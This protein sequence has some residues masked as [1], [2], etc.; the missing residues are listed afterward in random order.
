MTKMKHLTGKTLLTK[1]KTHFISDFLGF[2]TDVFL[3]GNDI[4]RAILTHHDRKQGIWGPSKHRKYW[5]HLFLLFSIQTYSL[6]SGSDGFQYQLHSDDS[7]VYIS[8]QTSPWISNTY[9]QL[10][11]D[12]STRM[13]NRHLEQKVSDKNFQHTTLFF[14]WSP[15]LLTA[16]CLLSLFL[17]PFPIH[18]SLSHFFKNIFQTAQPLYP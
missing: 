12:I 5:E 17:I 10:T 6:V 8:I 3:H 2:S 4:L 11:F 14:L 18:R 16:L 1:L 9:T 7:N 13:S 15:T